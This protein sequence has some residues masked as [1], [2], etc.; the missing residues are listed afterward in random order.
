M[1]QYEYQPWQ[2][3]VPLPPPAADTKLP[4]EGV[5]PAKPDAGAA[6][7]AGEQS[8][9]LAPGSQDDEYQWLILL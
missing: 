5:L 6:I 1:I 4:E 3:P 9:P 2:Q 8:P 7:P